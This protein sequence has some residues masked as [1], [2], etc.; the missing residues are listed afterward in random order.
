[1]S[2][3][4][5]NKNADIPIKAAV[6]VEAVP[7]KLKQT[8]E[9]SFQRVASNESSPSVDTLI[10]RIENASNGLTR[11]RHIRGLVKTW[12]PKR[13]TAAQR[14]RAIKVLT[15]AFNDERF[16]GKMAR[17]HPAAALLVLGVEDE[18]TRTSATEALRLPF[19]KGSRHCRMCEGFSREVADW[20]V[21]HGDKKGKTID[22]AYGIVPPKETP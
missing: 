18:A 4:I 22:V 1:M 11:I 20:T 6:D 15:L 14:Q 13:V 17:I 9:P 8:G 21:K 10:A 7:L 2:L 19:D 12:D 3:S 5:D 16:A